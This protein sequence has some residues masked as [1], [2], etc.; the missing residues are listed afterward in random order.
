MVVFIKKID[1]YFVFKQKSFKDLKLYF[2]YMNIETLT[3][4]NPEYWKNLKKINIV[5]MYNSNLHLKF[6]KA[7]EENN[8]EFFNAVLNKGWIPYLEAHKKSC[9]KL[10]NWDNYDNWKSN[11]KL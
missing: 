6:E 10:F 5:K 3:S 9:G 1:L 8:T 11:Q 4:L 2:I 7:D